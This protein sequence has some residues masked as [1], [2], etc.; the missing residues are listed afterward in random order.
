MFHGC[1]GKGIKQMCNLSEAIEEKAEEK[2][3]RE[4]NNLNKWLFNNGRV[5]DVE[6]AAKNPSY[7]K[8]LLAEM[9]A[10]KVK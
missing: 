1:N 10:T 8:K 9:K 5:S 3:A 4:I 7:Q 6:K 2:K